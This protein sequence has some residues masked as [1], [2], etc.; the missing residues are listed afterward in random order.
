LNDKLFNSQK[1]ED[2]GGSKS[3]NDLECNLKNNNDIGIEVKKA[4]TPDWMQ[5]SLKRNGNQWEASEKGK[6]PENARK[7]FNKFIQKIKLFDN[8]IPPFLEKKL[9]HKE[10]LDIKSVSKKFDDIYI[11]ISDDTI[12]KIYLAKNCKY[13]QISQYGLY[14]LAD[15]I[16]NFEVPLFK[17]KQKLRVRIKIHQK[18]LVAYTFIDSRPIWYVKGSWNCMNLLLLFLFK[19]FKNGSLE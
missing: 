2:L 11:D 18:N 8:N 6:I 14:R 15:D 13:I 19:I 9:T 12:N 4:K 5:C 7:E 16:C 17:V 10:W 3:C 1:L